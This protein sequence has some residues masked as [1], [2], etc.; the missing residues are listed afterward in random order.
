V[1]K[2]K[3]MRFRAC[4]CL[5]FAGVLSLS[6]QT[7]DLLAGL[8]DKTALGLDAFNGLA[9]ANN[10]TLRQANALVRRSNGQAQQSGL[11]PNPAV[12]YQ[13][14][15]IR[16]GDYGGGEQGAFIQQNFV[17]GGKLGLRKN[18]YR[19]Q[20]K[21]DEIG[22]EERRA[23]VLSDVGQ[24][25]YA[26]LAAQEQVKLQLQLLGI[27]N[28][29]VTTAKQLENVGQ[30]DAPDVLQAEVEA[31]QASLAH[32][33]AQRNYIQQFRELTAAVGKPGLPLAALSGDLQTI[34]RLN[35][36][37][38]L[39]T[40]VR[41]SP[42]VH[43]ANQNI[44]LAEAVLKAAKRESVPDL[45]VRAG[46]EK[47]NEALSPNSPRIVGAQGFATAG[48]TLPIF[49][50]NQGNVSAA[51]AD[52]ERAQSEVT[53]VELDL[54]QSLQVLTQQYSI[55]VMRADRYRNEIIPK[56]QR[57]YRLYLDKYRGMASAYPQ[58]IVSQRTMFQL[59]TQ[60]IQILQ[61]VWS[62]SIALQNFALTDGLSTPSATSAFETNLNLPGSSGA[63]VQ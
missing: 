21:S 6:A 29:A 22:I 7:G 2:D 58:V 34:P 26:A 46:M 17:L 41:D 44:R 13:G 12:G 60:Y 31:D 18:I 56:A 36:D 40:V 16:G 15:Q 10:P 4:F 28:D 55:D 33:A 50:R 53:R 30:A 51:S 63:G 45:T 52:L 57:A 14:E 8:A 62:E 20:R 9:L 59:R 24:R 37:G 23:R 27:A 3:E 5:L 19:E 25:F 42:V 35:P 39:E 11:W 47:N 32:V 54:R 43:R 48:I 1:S 61:D 38:L 49:N